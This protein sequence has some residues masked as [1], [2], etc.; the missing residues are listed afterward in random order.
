MF[1]PR[2]GAENRQAEGYCTRCGEWLPDLDSRGGFRGRRGPRTP[3]QRL[4]AMAI[5]SA[6]NAALALFSSV[7]LY[8]THLGRESEGDWAVYLA[9][10]FCLV[11]ATHQ[12]ISFIFN[13]QLQRRLKKARK[14]DAQARA[15]PPPE[16]PRALGAAE[17]Q[18]L[19]GVG[20]VTE[21]TTELLEQ[22]PR[23]G[24]GREGLR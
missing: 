14:S 5:F 24:A 9:A 7:A 13:L 2:C 6:L 3:E 12:T 17:A 8:A 22:P 18:P 21:G 11:I 19:G 15:V 16:E 1:C 4:R 23:R 10:A 20:S